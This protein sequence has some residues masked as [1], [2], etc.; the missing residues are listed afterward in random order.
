M[1]AVDGNTGNQN[2]RKIHS[3]CFPGQ[4]QPSG[5]ELA[6]AALPRPALLLPWHFMGE[7]DCACLKHLIRRSV[8]PVL[9][10]GPLG[11]LPVQGR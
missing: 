1:A 2:F 4:G 11:T 6:L 7:G 9:W 3:R 8:A 10:L 5:T